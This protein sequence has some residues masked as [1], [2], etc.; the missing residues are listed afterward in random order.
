[1]GRRW[2]TPHRHNQSCG[3]GTEFE[4]HLADE[5]ER[6]FMHEIYE[7]HAGRPCHFE[8]IREDEFGIP[9]RGHWVPDPVEPM[10]PEPPYTPDRFRRLFYAQG[11]GDEKMGNM[12]DLDR[13]ARGKAPRP[14]WLS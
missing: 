10:P 6:V 14:G 1:M 12:R 7:A 5:L 2:T 11:R 3:H 13:W 4:L 9:I 8:I